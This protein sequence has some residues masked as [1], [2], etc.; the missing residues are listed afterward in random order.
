MDDFIISLI[1]WTTIP[2]SPFQ[3]SPLKNN[4]LNWK[5]TNSVLIWTQYH[6]YS[7][8]FCFNA[9]GTAMDLFSP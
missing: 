5:C 7:T 2:Y 3:A 9:A 6:K 4:G 8:S 1:V